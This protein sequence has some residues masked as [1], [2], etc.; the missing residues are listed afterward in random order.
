MEDSGSDELD[1]G[2][3]ESLVTVVSTEVELARQCSSVS[4]QLLEDGLDELDSDMLEVPSA[5]RE[6][7]F[8]ELDPLVLALLVRL[9]PS[10]SRDDVDDLRLVTEP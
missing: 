6:V 2:F 7:E 5:W 10:D 3:I 4:E 9:I 1:V 8:S